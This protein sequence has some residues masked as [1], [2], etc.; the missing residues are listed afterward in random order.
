MHKFKKMLKKYDELSDDKK[1]EVR[2]ILVDHFRELD[3]NERK[4]MT[5]EMGVAIY[6]LPLTIDEAKDI[7]SEMYGHGKEGAKWTVDEIKTYIA[8]K[9]ADLNKEHYSLGDVYAFMHA[10]YYDQYT[11]LTM[12]TSEPSKVADYCFKMACGELDDE[13]APEQGKGKARK[14]FHYVV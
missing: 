7:V 6:G 3:K 1:E 2:E 8:N 11:F 10:K 12:L 4:D 5:Y 14:Y 13:D 9:G